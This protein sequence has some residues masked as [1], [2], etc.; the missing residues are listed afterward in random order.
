MRIISGQGHVFFVHINSGG[1]ELSKD[2]YVF[3]YAELEV[4][5]LE[6]NVNKIHHINHLR[7]AVQKNIEI[8]TLPLLKN[9]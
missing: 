7:R 9:I 4:H 8:R 5:F 1:L 6:N 2:F 3:R